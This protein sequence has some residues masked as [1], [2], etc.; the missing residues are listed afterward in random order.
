MAHPFEHLTE[1]RISHSSMSSF[2]G[3]PRKLEFSKFHLIT[4]ES[5]D[6]PAGSGKALHAGYQMYL[7]TKDKDA[8]IAAMMLEYPIHLCSDDTNSWSL[9]SCYNALMTMIN[10]R[11]MME[12]ELAKI[13]CVDGVVR[14][15]I[16]VPFEIRIKGFSL[17]DTREIPV[18]YTGFI[19]AIL[20]S[21][22]DNSYHELDIKTH[23]RNLKDMNGIYR[24]DDQCLPYA[25]VLDTVIGKHSNNLSVKYLSVFV[26]IVNA[27]AQ[28]YE[29]NRPHNEIE[30]WARGLMVDL[31]TIKMYYQLG[32]FRRQGNNC[33]NFN[34]LCGYFRICQSRNIDNI[35]N[36]LK[37][38]FN[39][40]NTG[41]QRPIPEPWVVVDLE[42]AA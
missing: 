25:F 35:R 37:L 12:Y 10:S 23:H 11:F 27:T 14:E 31:Q 9:E 28:L 20:Y 1:L 5:D 32:W 33:M 29:F 38:T 4:R 30:D 16:E 15:A 18:I 34:R 41:K 3:C 2:R 19:D 13:K 42:M 6:L 26:D 7:R 21:Y 39:N 8:A 22:L 17:D 36:F 24:F 40:L